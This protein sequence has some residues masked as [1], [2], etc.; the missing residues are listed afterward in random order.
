MRIRRPAVN[1]LYKF[2]I[3]QLFL[4]LFRLG[5]LPSVPKVLNYGLSYMMYQV[6]KY[7]IIV[8]ILFEWFAYKPHLFV[9]IR[10]TTV[11]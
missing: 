1:F 3:Y 8:V 5:F 7:F 10:S 2:N 4:K 6:V 11:Y 9:I